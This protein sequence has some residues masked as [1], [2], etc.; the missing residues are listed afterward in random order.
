MSFDEH[1]NFTVQISGRVPPVC[2]HYRDTLT[3]RGISPTLTAKKPAAHSQMPVAKKPSSFAYYNQLTKATFT[4]FHIRKRFGLK[5]HLNIPSKNQKSSRKSD[6]Y[7]C[8]IM[9]FTEP[10]N[11][12]DHCSTAINGCLP[13]NAHRL[14]DTHQ[15]RSNNFTN[16]DGP[17]FLEFHRHT[18]R[19]TYAV[20]RKDARY[21]LETPPYNKQSR[22]LNS[23][24][25]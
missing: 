10:N 11:H 19:H 14:P 1:C 5:E 7:M 17:F 18:Q 16:V 23:T 20:P 8:A 24:S 21:L 25:C 6:N 9:L 13:S 22:T 12:E 15:R 4:V 2:F 3:H